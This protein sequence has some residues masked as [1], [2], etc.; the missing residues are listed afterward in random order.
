MSAL[1]VQ[2]TYPIFTDIDGQPLEAGYIWIGT[3]NL[4]P[5]VNPIAVYWDAALTLPAAQPVR[6]LAGYPANNG[7]PARLYVNSDYSI[8]VMNKKGSVVYSA[9]AATER[10][11]EAILTGVDASQVTYTPPV[12]GVPTDAEE[13]FARYISVL[14]FGADPTGATDSTAAFQAALDAAR[15][16]NSSG[17]GR[18]VF[19]LYVPS[20]PGGFYKISNSLLIDGTHGMKIFGDGALT[21]RSNFPGSDTSATIRWYGGR[22]PIFHV[23]G[24]TDAVSN[25]NFFI[26]FQDLTISGYPTTVT[27]AT[28]VPAGMA[29]SAVHIGNID[30]F[31]ENTLMRHMVMENVWITNCRFGVWSGNPDGFNTDHATVNID[32]CYIS[33]CP[34]AGIAWGTGNAIAVVK[35]CHIVLN[36]W[37][38]AYFPA[39]DYMPQKGANIY[40]SSGYVDLISLTTAGA[41]TYKPTS[42]DIYQESGR[43]SIINA[44]SDTHGYF[45]YQGSASTITGGGYQVAQITGVRHWEG[46]MTVGTTPDS[47]F[48][49]A[50]GTVVTACAFYGNIVVQSGLSGK[51]VFAGIQFGRAGA[52]FTGSGVQTQRSLLNIGSGGGNFA[53]ITM[54]GA[55][56]GVPLT[57]KGNNPDPNMLFLNNTVSLFELAPAVASG[58]GFHW[59]ARGDDANGSHELYFNCYYDTAAGGYVPYQN[60][61]QCARVNLGGP[62]GFQVYVAD[63]NGS[64]G[65]L[66][67]VLASGVRTGSTAGTRAEAAW[68]FPKRA[69]D[70]SFSSGDWWE[71]SVYYN[72]ATNKLRVNTGG[73]TWID[74][75]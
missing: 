59:Y 16:A 15:G 46:S 12:G 25:P 18:T 48:I 61:K 40:V 39:D 22:A 64:S 43:V 11:N 17:V 56:A 68:E 21:Q 30:G 37:G 73:G 2:P 26:K 47:L 57:K 31:N 55:D 9:P 20:Y 70:P 74:L 35:G 50:P 54:G 5:Q 32:N 58:T 3:T 7:T 53:Q 34:Q 24:R 51:P 71:G 1:S 8:R 19:S 69:T 33:N 45:F 6:T 27:P 13:K 63:P 14:D 49:T 38:T 60:T 66:T 23:R 4:D 62:Q 29:L 65:I 67:W 10:Y 28:G 72:T 52:T 36:G 75:H 44:W 42:A 41:D